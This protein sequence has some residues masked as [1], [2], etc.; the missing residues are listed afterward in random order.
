MTRRGAR[1]AGGGSDWRSNWWVG[2][3]ERVARTFRCQRDST[4]A[5][6]GDW[7]WRFLRGAKVCVGGGVAWLNTGC[8]QAL[9]QD[10]RRHGGRG[11]SRGPQVLDALAT[12]R[13]RLWTEG[14]QTIA[15]QTTRLHGEEVLTR[16]SGK[17]EEKRKTG[18]QGC[19]CKSIIGS[20]GYI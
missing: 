10:A 11:N 15:Q 20:T 8:T 4:W 1:V 2:H 6:S 17:L 3:F 12:V 7:R 19:V 18:N 5:N 14:A 13:T 16:L 9:R